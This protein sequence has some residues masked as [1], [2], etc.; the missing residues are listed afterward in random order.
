MMVKNIKL[1][2]NQWLLELFKPNQ[3]L[4]SKLKVRL[5]SQFQG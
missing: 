3:Q 4:K 2:G 5:L 1:E